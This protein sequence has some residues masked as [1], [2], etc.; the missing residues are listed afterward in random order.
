MKTAV[1]GNF[2]PPP[3]P[4]NSL[5]PGDHDGTPKKV[6]HGNTK[7]G[8]FNKDRVE[9]V[10]PKRA[11]LER[12]CRELDA[13]DGAGEGCSSAEQCDEGNRD[14]DQDTKETSLVVVILNSCLDADA[15]RGGAVDLFV[16]EAVLNPFL[17]LCLL[18]CGW[19]IF[20]PL[21]GLLNIFDAL[22]VCLGRAKLLLSGEGRGCDVAR[23]YL[24]TPW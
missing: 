14:A 12:Q 24:V 13:R 9:F 22:L 5:S 6:P 8:P 10:A 20:N 18:S 15:R 21:P 16:L 2:P 19:S 3:H 1:L 11:D 23:S 7:P 17:A 4:N